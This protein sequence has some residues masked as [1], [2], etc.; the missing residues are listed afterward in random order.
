MMKIK[1]MVKEDLD[2][3]EEEN[4]PKDSKVLWLGGQGY[5][6][7]QTTEFYFWKYTATNQTYTIL[8]P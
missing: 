4:Q 2:Y 6:K 3:A 7:Q 1:Y 8:D 5:W